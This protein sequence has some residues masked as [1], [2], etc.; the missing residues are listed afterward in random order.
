[1][2]EHVRLTTFVL[3]ASIYTTP[4]NLDG[5]D[6]NAIGMYVVMLM[7]YVVIFHVIWDL[8]EC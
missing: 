8:N 1:M 2:H 4:I 3:A 5:A 7:L 6:A